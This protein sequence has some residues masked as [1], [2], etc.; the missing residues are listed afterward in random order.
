MRVDSRS[1]IGHQ[2]DVIEVAQIA[3]LEELEKRMAIVKRERERDDHRVFSTS[4]RWSDAG[5]WNAASSPRSRSA[6]TRRRRAAL[7]RRAL[8]DAGERQRAELDAALAAANTEQEVHT[9]RPP[10]GRQPLLVHLPRV[11]IEV[12]SPEVEKKGSTHSSGSART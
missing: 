3:Q 4:R 12:L 8:D 1:R 7:A 9:R 11:V 10:T 5:N 6:P 2:E